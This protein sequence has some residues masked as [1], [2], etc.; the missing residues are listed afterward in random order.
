[1]RR[2][3]DTETDAVCESYVTE[4]GFSL[5]LNAL[6]VREAE[7]AMVLSLDGVRPTGGQKEACHEDDAK[8]PLRRD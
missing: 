3:R 1:M 4:Q 2:A 8:K 6:G 7:V 5:L